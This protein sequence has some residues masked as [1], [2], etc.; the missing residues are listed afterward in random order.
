MVEAQSSQGVLWARSIG[1]TVGLYVVGPTPFPTL[2]C[3]GIVDVYGGAV[4]THI[5]VEWASGG[6]SELPHRRSAREATVKRSCST[7]L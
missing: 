7:S 2:L 6:L 3:I 4:S 5:F 1:R